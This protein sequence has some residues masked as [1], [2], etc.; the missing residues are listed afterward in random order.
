M[1]NST[2]ARSDAESATNKMLVGFENVSDCYIIEVSH[3]VLC[4]LNLSSAFPPPCFC[5]HRQQ[6]G[7]KVY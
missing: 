1:G 2:E 3:F 7:V 4:E 6:L 5:G